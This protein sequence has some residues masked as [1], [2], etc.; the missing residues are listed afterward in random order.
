MDISDITANFKNQLAE[1]NGDILPPPK[2]TGDIMLSE[3]ERDSKAA[4]LIK[5]SEEKVKSLDAI[6]QRRKAQQLATQAANE[7]SFANKLGLDSQGFA[8]SIVNYGASLFSGTT[9]EAG[10][11]SSLSSEAAGNLSF[12]G[13]T[14]IQVD[15]RNRKMRGIATPEDL[16]I[17]NAPYTPVEPAKRDNTF[18]LIKPIDSPQQKLNSRMYPQKAAQTVDQQFDQ[19]EKHWATAKAITDATD[20]SSTVNQD[21]RRGMTEDLSKTYAEDSATISKGW[22]KVFVDDSGEGERQVISGVASLLFNAGKAVANNPGATFEYILENVPQIVLGS[23]RKIGTKALAASNIGYAAN[24]YRKGIEE[25]KKENGGDLPPEDIREGMAWRSASLAVAEQAGEVTQLRAI[26]GGRKTTGAAAEVASTF[27]QRLLTRGG[28]VGN[29]AVTEGGTEIYQTDTEARIKQKEATGFELY[30]AGTIGAAVGGGMVAGASVLPTIKDGAGQIVKNSIDKANTERVD[31]AGFDAAVTTNDPSMYLDPTDKNNYNPVKAAQVLEAHAAK[32]DTEQ[33]VKDANLDKVAEIESNLRSDIEV[34]KFQLTQGSPAELETLNK[35]LTENQAKLANATPEQAVEIQSDIDMINEQLGIK[36]LAPKEVQT[37]NNQIRGLEK[38]LSSVANLRNGMTRKALAQQDAPDL[39]AA[40][41]ALKTPVDPN[42]KVAQTVTSKAPDF[43]PSGYMDTKEWQVIDAQLS[44]VEAQWIAMESGPESQAFYEKNVKDLQSQKDA[45][46]DAWAKNDPA[47]GSVNQTVNQPAAK[48]ATPGDVLINLAMSSHL[49][50]DP[51]KILSPERAL[52]FANDALNA[53]TIPQREYLRKFS[54]AQA[55]ENSLKTDKDVANEIYFGVGK[56]MGIADYRSQI[57]QALTQGHLGLAE[58]L[59]K[60]LSTFALDH[61]SKAAA[62]QEAFKIANTANNKLAQ[63]V[64]TT[65]GVWALNKGKLLTGQAQT[66][67]GAFIIHRSGQKQVSAIQKESDALTAAAE[68][69]QKLVSLT[70]GKAVSTTA[71]TKTTEAKQEVKDEVPTDP[72]DATTEEVDNATD[73]KDQESTETKADPVAEDGKLEVYSSPPSVEGTP[74]TERNLVTDFTSQSAGNEATGTVRPL[75][76]V[77]NFIS[78]LAQTPELALKYLQETKLSD[79]QQAAINKLVAVVQAWNPL[80]KLALFKEAASKYYYKNPMQY[81]INRVQAIPG[82][83]PDYDAEENVKTAISFAAHSLILDMASRLE[84][85]SPASINAILFRDEDHPVTAEETN[86]LG[87]AGTRA[88]VLRNSSGMVGYQALGIQT[89]GDA[90][91]NLAGNIQSG[92]GS[93]V[94]HLL[95]GLG[96]MVATVIPTSKIAEMMGVPVVHRDKE[97][98]PLFGKALEAAEKIY[99]K[100]EQKF[101]RLVNSSDLIDSDPT[102]EKMTAKQKADIAEKIAALKSITDSVKGSQNVLDDLFS[103][104]PLVSMARLKPTKRNQKYAKGTKREI[105]VSEEKIMERKHKEKNVLG[106]FLFQIMDA[107]DPVYVERFSGFEEVDEATTHIDN[108]LGIEANNLSLRRQYEQYLEQVQ[109]LLASGE[110]NLDQPVYLTFSVWKN[111]RVGIATNGINPQTSKMQRQLM[112]MPDWETEIDISNVESFTNFKF[113]I[114][115]GLGFKADEKLAINQMVNVDNIINHPVIQAAVELIRQRAY[116]GKDKFTDIEQDAIEVAVTRGGQ[117]M[118]S[119]AALIGLA[120]YEQVAV[121]NDKTDAAINT[122]FKV[123][124]MA[125][126]DGKV[127][128]SML[129]SIVFGSGTIDGEMY[130]LLN[131]GGF[132]KVG[133]SHTQFNGW[134]ENPKN[135]DLYQEIIYMVNRDVSGRVKDGVLDKTLWDTVQVFTGSLLKADDTVTSGGRKIIKGPVQEIVFGA[136]L[137]KTI[138]NMANQFVATVRSTIEDVAKGKNL[139]TLPNLI[140]ALN[141]LLPPN[142]QWSDGTSLQTLLNGKLKPEDIASMKEVFKYTMGE[143]V[144]LVVMA[145]FAK[146]LENRQVFNNTA[147]LSYSLYNAAYTVI[148]QQVVNEVFGSD[149]SAGRDLSAKQEKLVEERVLAAYPSFHS[150]FSKE[151]DQ[152]GASF[153]IF[154]EERKI[155]LRPEYST[156]TEFNTKIAGTNDKRINNSAYEIVKG[157]PGVMLLP[158]AIHSL[159]SYISHMVQRAMHVLNVHDAVIAGFGT[160]KEAAQKMNAITWDAIFK[161]SPQREMF[162]GSMRVLQ[163]L[164]DMVNSETVT[165]ELLAGLQQSINDQTVAYNKRHSFKERLT[166]RQFLLKQIEAIKYAAYDADTRKFTFLSELGFIDQYTFEGGNYE[167]KQ[168]QRD[169]AKTALDKVPTWELNQAELDTI[170]AVQ[171]A[172][173]TYSHLEVVTRTST[174]VEEDTDVGLVE[175]NFTPAQSIQLLSHAK[176]DES[177]S[178]TVRGWVTQVL[179]AMT[180][181]QVKLSLTAALATLGNAAAAQMTQLLTERYNRIPA[182]LW[183]GRGPATIPSDPEWVALFD[184]RPN[185]T[186][187]QLVSLLEKKLE[188]EGQAMTKPSDKAMNAFNRGLLKQLAAALN[189][190]VKVQYVTSATDPSQVAAAPEGNARGWYIVTKNGVDTIY[191]LSP[192]F[193]NS[194]LQTEVLLHELFHSTVVRVMH[195]KNPSPEVKEILANLEVLREKAAE[196]IEGKPELA[197]KYAAAVVNLDELTAWGMTSEGFQNDVLM[198]IKVPRINTVTGKNILIT[199]M[200][201]FITQMLK[202]VFSRDKTQREPHEKTVNGMSVMVKNVAGIL[203]EVKNQ[204][205]SAI[206]ISLSM[207]N[208]SQNLNQDTSEIFEALSDPANPTSRQFEGHLRD[209]LGGIIDKLHGPADTFIDSIKASRAVTHMDRYLKA[210]YSGQAPYVSAVMTSGFKIS[211]QEAFVIEQIEATVRQAIDRNE[212]TLT[213]AYKQLNQLFN[214]AKVLIQPADLDVDPA[215]GQKLYDFLFNLDASNGSRVDHLSRFAAMGLAHEQVNKLL[216]QATQTPA[217][218]A[219]N[220]SLGARLRQILESILDWFNVKV[221]GTYKGQQAD[222]KLLTL[223][224]QL[225]DIESRKIAKLLVPQN[226]RIAAI[227]STMATVTASIKT[228]VDQAGRSSFVTNSKYAVFRAAGAMASTVAADR[229][230]AFLEALNMFHDKA[231]GAKQGLAMGILNYIGGPKEFLQELLRMTKFSETQRQ[232]L[233]TKTGEFVMQSFKNGGKDLTTAAKRSITRVLLHTDVQSLL[234]PYTLEQIAAFLGTGNERLIEIQALERKLAGSPHKTY[235]IKQAQALAWSLVTGKDLSANQMRNAPNIARLYGT[236]LTNRLTAV[237]LAETTTILDQLAT[238][239]ALD[240]SKPNERSAARNVMLDEINRVVQDP[241]DKGNGV[242]VLLKLHRQLLADSHARLFSGAEAHIA[243]GYTP[244]VYNP[245]TEVTAANRLEGADLLAKGY[246]LVHNLSRDVSDPSTT[247]LDLYV[248]KDGGLRPHPTGIASQTDS[249]AQGSIQVHGNRDQSTSSGRFN[250]KKMDEI[251]TARMGLI[252]DLNNPNVRFDPRTATQ[253][254]MSPLLDTNGKVMNYRY[255]MSSDLRD[256][257]LER[258]NNFELLMGVMAGTTYDKVASAVHNKRAVQALFEFHAVDFAGRSDAYLEVG[259]LSSDPEMREIY[260]LMPQQMKDDV[261]QIWGTDQMY[262]RND[263]I[264]I[265]FG[266]RKHSLSTVFDKEVYEREGISKVFAAT[267]EALL[268]VYAR[269]RGMSQVDAD[270]YALSA[271]I[272][273][274]RAE[275]VWLAL[276]AEIK[277]IIVVRSGIVLLGN[278]ISNKGLLLAAG[279]SPKDVVMNSIEAIKGVMQHHQDYDEMFMLEQQV[280]IGAVVGNLADTQQRILDLKNAIARNPVKE[281]IDLGLLPTIVEDL[282]I[283]TDRYSYKTRLTKKID[284]IGERF[285]PNVLK[286]AKIAYMGK[287][288][289][290]YALLSQSTQMSDFVARYVMFK[291]LTTKRVNPLSSAQA[292]QEA[293]EMFV[294]YD[295]PMPRGLQYMDDMGFLPFTKYFLSIQ[296]VIAKLTRDHPIR[297]LMVLSGTNYLDLM[298]SVFDSSMASRIGNNPLYSGALRFPETV[299]DNML[300]QGVGSIFK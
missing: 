113:R 232:S 245:Y 92:I 170:S 173:D 279:V 105:P 12:A 15:A 219:V 96:Y 258:D 100:S 250:N 231:V 216:Q 123:N 255:M 153:S 45:V 106:D 192:E 297:S 4:E 225:V 68:D 30:E 155:S 18:D 221:T 10:Q 228:K 118:H 35:S 98:N 152:L 60:K 139:T 39:D 165:N 261:K 49:Q 197:A 284:K 254:F 129:A 251:K 104:D 180:T 148:R 24:E 151:D 213:S 300:L 121:D 178:D 87:R 195:A 110:K 54:A 169:E 20:F 1:N 26:M 25:Y 268:V 162:E 218:K 144:K 274:R 200:K 140:T 75:V 252:A 97:G 291:H 189:P 84:I 263:M 74:Y 179:T 51:K 11:I 283:D 66:E 280:A 286:F 37:L 147:N 44:P 198:Q 72:V 112:T 248:R 28:A 224:E 287:K 133:D 8:G 23:I 226:K 166:S 172:L 241:A 57:S 50:T 94:E 90:A 149:K 62:A 220:P 188:S 17:L 48:V 247:H 282:S 63:I 34:A 67:A 278:V 281:L 272:R 91:A 239:Y 298:P 59:L 52:E 205:D 161:Y 253:T 256:T 21:N 22:D 43:D 156:E 275:D 235:F 186:G 257:L 185:L 207:A 222:Q 202:L 212:N 9:R 262:V 214:E 103:V 107:F 160:I 86:L 41:A 204:R 171:D 217:P 233:I 6:I 135:R 58:T 77:K 299:N 143:S 174:V 95:V 270:R 277:D 36:P 32:A 294:N 288:T 99:A 163:G 260:R 131:R 47:N 117:N 29:A 145:N 70:T 83:K 69:L 85:N 183:G 159:D 46:R 175:L 296:R 264:D 78:K 206:K 7:K 223:A 243:K 31:R 27:K 82:K 120:Q 236:S 88:S 244:E 249:K 102:A 130:E 3:M 125:E 271:G 229:L 209:L 242:E 109:M 61:V 168:S 289:K 114:A 53:L 208:T 128:G 290:T 80:V 199:G 132:Y 193:T 240:F 65:D 266:Y 108:R 150:L 79:P 203:S 187:K 55:L 16:A 138:D 136:S 71:V 157:E 176:T 116:E 142:R 134:K 227:E 127:N 246:K 164:A 56:N 101:Y 122:K 93:Y 167:V 14:Q 2:F 89:N 177:L 137:S 141:T 269:G 119:L 273:V 265:T 194:G 154:K 237:Q 181:G 211:D 295:I 201:T 276:A 267:V 73:I 191:I 146:F 285:N 259:P 38:Q 210:L 196:F 76:A 215:V 5:A 184:Q 158:F 19:A 42:A 33:T 64:K 234:G 111:L 115:E 40:I 292:A 126:V 124:L 238:L 230:G 13:L 293:S 81:L 190:N 182:S